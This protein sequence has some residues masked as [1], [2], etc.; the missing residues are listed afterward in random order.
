MNWYKMSKSLETGKLA[1]IF[2]ETSYNV[3]TSKSGHNTILR[4]Y[5]GDKTELHGGWL[6]LDT[7]RLWMNCG[8]LGT[9]PRE[10]WEYIKDY[11]INQEY[12]LHDLVINTKTGKNRVFRKSRRKHRAELNKSCPVRAEIRYAMA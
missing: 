3:T 5:V 12:Y 8:T 11:F 10:Y 6:D 2:N 4:D 7:E 9:V 1:F